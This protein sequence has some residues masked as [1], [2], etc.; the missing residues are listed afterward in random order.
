MNSSSRKSLLPEKYDRVLKGS[1]GKYLMSITLLLAGSLIFQSCSHSNKSNKQSVKLT[2][3]VDPFIGTGGHGHVYPGA[4]IPFGMVQLS[5]DNGSSGWDY[6]SGYNY[7]SN[8]ITG[9]SMTHLSGTGIGDLC[10]ISF[11]P[12][13]MSIEKWQGKEIKKWDVSTRFLHKNEQAVPGYYSVILNN[14]IKVELSATKRAGIYRYTFPGNGNVSVSLTLGFAINWDHPTDTYIKVV[15][16]HTIEGY[17]KS[18]GWAKDQRVYFVAK[19]SQPFDHFATMKTNHLVEGQKEVRGDSVKAFFSFKPKN[20]IVLEK[21]G[22]SAVNIK[23]A[24]ENLNTDISNWNFYGVRKKASKLWEDQLRKIHV[25]STD[26]SSI[27]K[28]YTALY[29]SML[30]PTIFSDV[31]RKY[32]GADGKIHSN[33]NFINYT[34][35]SLW[36]TYRAEDPLFTI[37]EPERINDMVRSFLAFYR[38]HGLL[39]IWPLVGNETN[40]MIG[41]HAIPVIVDAYLK[42]FRNYDV[43][44]AFKA[45]KK[46]AEEENKEVKEFN[47]LGYVPSDKN[48][49]SVSKTLEYAYDDWCIAQ[50]AKAL[51]KKKDYQVYMQRAKF[52]KNLFD[53]DTKFMR[54]KLANGKWETPFDPLASPTDFKKRDYTEANAWQ[55]NWYVPQDVSNLIQMMGGDQ[56][57]IN[58]LDKFFNMKSQSHGDIAD[59]SGMIGQYVQ[60]NE[61]DM[62][63]PYLYNYAGVPWK[64]QAIVRK[65]MTDL[66]KDSNS[67]L[68]GNEDCGQM[69]AWYIFSAIGFYPV[70]PVSGKFI[71]G[72]P[73]FDKL[74]I[75]VSGRQYFTIIA[76]NNSRQNKY[77]QS[78]TLNGDPYDK[79]YINYAD[80]MLGGTLILKMG[81]KPN[82]KWGSV[83]KSRP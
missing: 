71:L 77:I 61:P 70:N 68:P 49:E 82:K 74:S 25:A 24:E 13:T 53:P 60:G 37:I 23:G 45:M 26:T 38:Q 30:A 18:S 69:S 65:I 27:V 20:S 80:I 57:F 35:F 4:T 16:D 9:F 43:D 56:A 19:F 33:N 62:Q 63:T 41:Y 66:Y 75:N 51:E 32:Q 76:K 44:E 2:S 55:Y 42:G 21:V 48:S 64:T 31:N 28:F 10:D 36:D 22:I 52:Y 5:P 39:P 50:M 29:H 7:A 78:A 14:K 46:S 59:M 17:R 12:T 79:N 47:E 83:R 72:S 40:T 1:K 8:K 67:G 81:D 3:Y 15:N 54:P 73:V 58:R 11:M 34:T 6:C